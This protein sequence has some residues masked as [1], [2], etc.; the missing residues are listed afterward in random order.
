MFCNGYLTPPPPHSGNGGGGGGGNFS[1]YGGVDPSL[2]PELA[3]ALRVSMEEERQRQERAAAEAGGSGAGA[4]ATNES[5]PAAATMAAADDSDLQAA[6]ALSMKGMDTGA[7]NEQASAAER[8]VSELT[9]EEQIL[10]AMQLSMGGGASGDAGSGKAGEELTNIYF[11]YTQ[12]TYLT[13]TVIRPAPGGDAAPAAMAE[14][15]NSAADQDFLR[16]VLGSLEG[17]DADAVLGSLQGNDE[18]KD[19]DKKDKK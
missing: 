3:L 16:G 4:S 8:D 15:D 19:E 11:I 14:D 12:Q 2:D 6:V 10:R 13:H 1:E 7:D 9:E 5:A 17:V 18:K